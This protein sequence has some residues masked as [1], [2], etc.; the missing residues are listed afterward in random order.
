MGSSLS[1]AKETLG[2]RLQGAVMAV[3]THR[4]FYG[5][6]KEI[7]SGISSFDWVAGGWNVFAKPDLKSSQ[8]FTNVS[9]A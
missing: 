1:L 6:E 2:G 3:T 9:S 4:L 7:S 5:I 8:W